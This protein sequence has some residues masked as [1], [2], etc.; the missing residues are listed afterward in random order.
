VRRRLWITTFVVASLAAV[1]SGYVYW[2][3]S[4]SHPPELASIPAYPSAVPI[5]DVPE[6]QRDAAERQLRDLAA[7]AHAGYRIVGERFLATKVEFIWDSLRHQLTSY[8]GS[9]GYEL[10]GGGWSPDFGTYYNSYRHDGWLRPHFND[11]IIVDAGLRKS[12]LRTVAGEHV[13]VYGYFHLA[14]N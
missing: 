7:T 12:T 5:T 14:P 2:Q 9:S 3:Y 6:P 13:H 1:I 10:D 4:T 8:L 11:D